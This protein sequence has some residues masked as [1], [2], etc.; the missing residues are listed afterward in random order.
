MKADG[1]PAV[2]DARATEL[3]GP[4]CDNEWPEVQDMDWWSELQAA[5]GAANL[6]A[7]PTEAEFEAWLER[8]EA[9]LADHIDPPVGE[10]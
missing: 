3:T 1:E 9:T 6:S 7:V 4:L 2:T 5:L 8:R 10:E